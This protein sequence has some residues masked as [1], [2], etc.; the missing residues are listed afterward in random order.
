MHI[1]DMDAQLGQL[2]RA[3]LVPMRMKQVRLSR[4]SDADGRW[5]RS[6]SQTR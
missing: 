5:L 1:I 2:V 4:A 3:R 6:P